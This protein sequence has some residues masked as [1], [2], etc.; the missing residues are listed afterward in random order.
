[1]PICGP[2]GSPYPVF[3]YVSNSMAMLF[4]IPSYPMYI[5]YPVSP[6]V[7]APEGAPW[8]TK[9]NPSPIELALVEAGVIWNWNVVVNAEE[10]GIAVPN[11][12]DE[13]SPPL[14]VSCSTGPVRTV[15][16]V[17]ATEPFSA[18]FARLMLL[19]IF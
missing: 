5:P 18:R 1:M 14:L 7:A 11:H 16:A 2:L 4:G 10:T 13:V 15:G 17:G 3:W 8:I 12:A 6:K 9:A 19:L